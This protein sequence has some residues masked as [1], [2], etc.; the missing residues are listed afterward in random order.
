LL[1]ATLKAALLFAAGKATAGAVST[2]AA[3]LANE[4]LKA[5][6]LMKMKIVV[7][8]FA[9]LSLVGVG[10]GA[11]AQPAV[12][13]P[14]LKPPETKAASVPRAEDDRQARLDDY[15]DPLPDG[16]VRR[17][18]TLRFRQGGGLGGSVFPCPDG[19]TVISGFYNGNRT[20]CL[21]DLA[22]GKLLRSFPTG[23]SNILFALS[24][25]GRTLV[26]TH[27]ANW[28]IRLWDVASGKESAGLEPKD[29]CWP[30]SFA[31]SPDGKTLAAGNEMG[32]V[33]LWDLTTRKHSANLK[34]PKEQ[35]HAVAFTSDGK[36]LI[37]TAG[38]TIILWDVTSRKE[39]RTLTRPMN[40][41]FLAVSPNG[42]LFASGSNKDGIALWDVSNG[43]I[44]HE[45]PATKFLTSM[46]FSPNG[47]TLVSAEGNDDYDTIAL[48]DVS[49][50]K[51]RR[52]NAPGVVGAA[53][54]KDG[55]TLISGHIGGT[56]RVWD[57]ETGKKRTLTAGNQRMTGAALSPDG[58]TLAF[59]R[60]KLRCF[61]AGEIRLWDM[62]AGREIGGLPVER[63]SGN[64]LAFAP[65]GKSL[66]V[67]GG[68]A[69]S[70]WDVGA[71]KLLRRLDKDNFLDSGFCA[72][73]FTPD[74]KTLA[75]GQSDGSMRLW[76]IAAGNAPRR[77][78]WKTKQDKSDTYLS[79][80]AFAPDGE[81]L[82]AAGESPKF[83]V[84]VR[85]WDMSAAEKLPPLLW[86]ASTSDL[87]GSNDD[88]PD[89]VGHSFLP[90]ILFTADGHSLAVQR[91]QKT[92]PIWEAVSGKERLLLTGHNELV[93][94][95]A[96]APDGRTLA[97]AG[98]DDTIRLWDLGTGEELRSLTGHRGAVNSL[99]FSADGNTLVSTGDDTTM[100]FW[101]VAEVTHRP[102]P[103]GSPLSPEDCQS[104]WTDLADADASKAYKAIRAFSAAPGQTASFIGDRLHP[105]RSANKVEVG[106]L[107]ADLDSDDFDI[108]DK[109]TG[110]LEELGDAAGPALR[111]ANDGQPSAEARSRVN[112]LLEK[113]ATPTPELLRHLRALEALEAVGG[114]EARRVVDKIANGA[115]ES[116]LTREAKACLKRM[117]E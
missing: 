15:G 7:M 105:A 103:K 38:K 49:G 84:R 56:I 69:I 53:Y 96:V 55:K 40:I 51:D 43:K 78:A 98:C 20:I 41:S 108:R 110:K 36:T 39:L 44:V 72:A 104:L 65:N 23:Y 67:V 24:Q 114:A 60:D 113:L 73:A 34:T 77:F 87:P 58:R 92:I 85:M 75:T 83:G 64:S 91:Y 22:T 68:A 88:V 99:V 35:I 21:W 11:M 80:V 97:S 17:V 102:R 74:G 10:V 19:K 26:E 1:D 8:M 82:A 28:K 93:L 14:E 89:I 79:A 62:A 100:L 32:S 4:S 31:F 18:G 71:R 109:A 59:L 16:A 6:G 9:V 112:R 25:D 27:Q 116:R 5:M 95:E 52:V 54:S 48:R 117:S 81:R 94:C 76:D 63:W 2:T 115:A 61:D 12:K 46:D 45:W 101:D 111:K 30:S 47:K 29:G 57:A 50:G 86:E 13:P 42:A 66:A 33:D 37:A 106:R 107:I 70:L 3:A 90:S